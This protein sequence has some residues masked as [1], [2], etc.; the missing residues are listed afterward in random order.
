LLRPVNAAARG[1]EEDVTPM[2]RRSD[3][4]TADGAG[5]APSS[6]PSSSFDQA[7]T[8]RRGSQIPHP[9]R[10]DALSAQRI[11]ETAAR[12]GVSTNPDNLVTNWNREATELL[13]HAAHDVIGQNF[14]QVT[15]AR[16]VFGNPLCH[17]HCAFHL[18][19]RSGAAPEGFELDVF[20]RTGEKLRVG[21]SVVVVLGPIADEYNLVYLLTPKRRRRRA[22][23]AIDRLLS[24]R[25][26]A[27]SLP[28]GADQR[29]RRHEPRLTSRQK[30]V[31]ALMVLGRNSS[32]I[33][34]ELGVSI[35]TV[36]SHV[37]AVFKALK[38][39]TRVEAVSRAISGRML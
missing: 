23:E 24:E 29:G 12:A 28:T 18:M 38:V 4:Q 9:R 25:G 2:T 27:G 6:G 13:G 32:E 33:A 20:T 36:R 39:S 11:V 16:D 5:S 26:L 19:A 30:E 21:V 14:Q 22:D 35:H 17:Q 1:Q 34:E 8:P 3:H 37:Q 15:R 31:L 7:P 10:P